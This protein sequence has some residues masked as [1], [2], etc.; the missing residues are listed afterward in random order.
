MENKV[1]LSY[2]QSFIG[3]SGPNEL[4]LIWSVKY[5]QSPKV[6]LIAS[7]A[8]AT[9]L[10]CVRAFFTITA[11][12]DSSQ[13]QFLQS[14]QQQASFLPI[15]H[16]IAYL[17]RQLHRDLVVS[18]CQRE[19]FAV[20]QLHLLKCLRCLIK[21]TPYTKLRPGLVYKL[22]LNLNILLNQKSKYKDM[23]NTMLVNEL[24]NCL[25]MILTNNSQ[26]METHLALLATAS[27]FASNQEGQPDLSNKLEQ[28]KV[29]YKLPV[30]TKMPV[31]YFYDGNTNFFFSNK[32][33]LNSSALVSGQQTPSL[34]QSFNDLISDEDSNPSFS[35][36]EIG[37]GKPWLVDF[38]VQNA[39]MTG[40]GDQPWRRIGPSCLSLLIVICSKYF[41]VMRKE[42]FLDEI[43]RLFM[44]K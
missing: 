9:Y 4:N 19:H 44:D 37:N 21:S 7:Q 18:L 41:D 16:T 10:E 5:D 35:R 15:S 42:A 17:I 23:N 22:I 38:C 8:L 20:N 43:S 39:R 13:P 11:S 32:S 3:S 30:L 26:M 2:W 14:Q 28:L 34:H 27:I 6:R 33:S 24:L 31:T 1:V 12:E 29:N 25:E 40:E 36:G